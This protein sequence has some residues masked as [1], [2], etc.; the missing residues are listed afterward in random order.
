[1]FTL[2]ILSTTLLFFYLSLK[3][4]DDPLTNTAVLNQ[5]CQLECT[6]FKKSFVRTSNS[7][8]PLSVPSLTDPL[9]SSYDWSGING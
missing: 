8:Y 5:Y 4:T 2:F 6:A 9:P 1:M 3:K 7:M